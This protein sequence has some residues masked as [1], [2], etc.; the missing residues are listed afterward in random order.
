M[1]NY[2]NQSWSLVSYH[3]DK[4]KDVHDAVSIVLSAL[5]RLSISSSAMKTVLQTKT[6]NFHSMWRDN[7]C[8]TVPLEGLT[9]PISRHGSKWTRTTTTFQTMM[10]NEKNQSE[11][12]LQHLTILVESH[13][14]IGDCDF[15]LNG[16]WSDCMAK[17]RDDPQSCARLL[18]ADR[19]QLL[20]LSTASVLKLRKM[21]I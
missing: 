7:R 5:A 8:S 19:L 21:G 4:I 18:Y 9:K 20:Q 16:R 2:S 1:I 15:K 11:W 10:S 6:G 14:K 13:H 3:A 12:T 17:W